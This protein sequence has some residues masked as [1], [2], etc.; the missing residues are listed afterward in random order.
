MRSVKKHALGQAQDGDIEQ[1]GRESRFGSIHPVRGYCSA[2]YCDGHSH[3]NI[4]SQAYLMSVICKRWKNI[5]SLA[6]EAVS[7]A[8]VDALREDGMVQDVPFTR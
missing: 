7:A 4:P 8:A 3:T 6:S 2:P 1:R 5:L